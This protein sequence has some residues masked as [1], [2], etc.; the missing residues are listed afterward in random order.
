MFRQQDA[1]ELRRKLGVEGRFTVGFVGRFWPVKG[2]DTLIKAFALL[3]ADTML[4]LVGEGSERSNLEVLA[5]ALGV[6]PR[7]RWVPWVNS[8]DVP[9][10]M[11][12][13]DVLVLPSR[14]RW[15]IK[16]QFGRVLVEA[17][18]CETCVVGS[19]SGEISNVVGDA[20]LIFHEED[21]RALA[22]RLQ[23]L[24][25]DSSQRQLFRP[26]G[27][28]RVVEHFSYAKIARDT[29]N[30]YNCVCSKNGSSCL[31]QYSAGGRSSRA[32]RTL[33]CLCEAGSYIEGS[34]CPKH[35][36]KCASLLGQL[37]RA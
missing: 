9:E 15:N 21:E 10:Y 5:Q 25:D 29:V 6:F 27:R 35:R 34:S 13:F 26:R 17:M 14:T 33:E 12:A 2:V 28:D 30:F 1:T 36:A 37:P 20:S 11:N 8:W 22:D 7:V 24:M 16:E 32:P 3:P 18:A 31:L 19:D 4:V 23:L